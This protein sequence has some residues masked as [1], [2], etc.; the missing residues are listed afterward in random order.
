MAAT[1]EF[2]KEKQRLEAHICAVNFVLRFQQHSTKEKIK[3][4]AFRRKLQYDLREF[5]LEN[6]HMAHHV[7]GQKYNSCPNYNIYVNIQNADKILI[8]IIQKY[9]LILLDELYIYKK[10]HCVLKH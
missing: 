5:I 7:I 4:I 9:I 10:H 8:Q 1:I 2:E 3:L 6:T